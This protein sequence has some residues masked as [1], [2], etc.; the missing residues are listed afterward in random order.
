MKPRLF[1]LLLL[2]SL[3]CL[4]GLLGS[5]KPRYSYHKTLFT[6]IL[7]IRDKI[8][9]MSIDTGQFRIIHAGEYR[10]YEFPARII[11]GEETNDVVKTLSDRIVFKPFVFKVGSLWG[12]MLENYADTFNV[13]L[14]V[15][16][17]LS[18]SAFFTLSMDSVLSY[19]N[20]CGQFKIANRDLVK[21]YSMRHDF[22]DSAYFYFNKSKLPIKHALSER[23]DKENNAK[24]YKL[25][26]LSRKDTGQYAEYLNQRK[27]RKISF[28]LSNI[29][30]DNEKQLDSF[31][32]RF[33]K[34]TL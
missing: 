6:Y 4:G 2:V 10:I 26:I 12:Y 19:A 7:P 28:E 18:S 24:L 34:E 16:S 30:V 32:T 29:V 27:F 15:D 14:K 1:I 8:D 33:K 3:L 22:Y 23:L 17:V 20:Y 21:A 31:L 9:A 25:E 5:N 11:K 13:K